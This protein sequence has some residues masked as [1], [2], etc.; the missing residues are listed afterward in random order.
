MQSVSKVC[1]FNKPLPRGM[2][3]KMAT[4]KVSELSFVSGV[5][6]RGLGF[7][8]NPLVNLKSKVLCGQPT[9]K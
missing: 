3:L 7:L 8:K 4:L 9:I 5:I 1:L 2:F 6:G